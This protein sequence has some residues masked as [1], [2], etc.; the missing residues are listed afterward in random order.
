MSFPVVGAIGAV[1]ETPPVQRFL[2]GVVDAIAQRGSS[3]G[4]SGDSARFSALAQA[5]ST[6]D[7]TALREAVSGMSRTKLQGMQAEILS[8]FQTEVGKLF[9]DKNIDLSQEIVLSVQ[10]GELRVANEHPDAEAINAV[11]EQ[12]PNLKGSFLRLAGIG[13]ALQTLDAHSA[14]TGP[15]AAYAS[16]SSAVQGN[17]F[18]LRIEGEDISSFFSTE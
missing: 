10:D 18:N 17:Q 2:N 5:L 1:L 7:Q 3:S 16:Q 13:R 6:Q 8:Q 11:L 4:V 12:V 9:P 14:T 15:F